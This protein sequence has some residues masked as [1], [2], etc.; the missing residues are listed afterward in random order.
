MSDLE[1]ELVR[2]LASGPFHRA[3]SLAVRR[4][5]LT[6]DRLCHRLA[7]RDIRLSTAA[8]SYWA[9]GR[10]RP[11]RGDSLKGVVAL[12]EVLGLPPGA[13]TALLP[14]PRPRG[15]Y[16]T[17]LEPSLRPWRAGVLERMAED[18]A[19]PAHSGLRR[20]SVDEHVTIDAE[21]CERTRRVREVMR[22][23]RD[24]LSRFYLFWQVD[25]P[26]A[27][28]PGFTDLWGCRPGRHRWDPASGYLITEMLLDSRLDVGDTAIVRYT[29][30]LPGHTPVTR[31]TRTVSRTV[32]A[33]ALEVTFAPGTVPVRCASFHQAAADEADEDLRDL[34]VDPS[35]SVHLALIEARPG[36][37]GIQ[38]YW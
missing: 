1:L 32:H 7:E 5:G 31:C 34:R 6:L 12:E 37:Y 22:A 38:L 26:T 24:D 11:E 18:L 2:A 35:G 33:F 3:L 29:L 8:L 21:R 15:R 16:S 20:L 14:P 25:D 9:S 23:E 36:V 28:R 4:R 27:G 19:M 10:R 13:L 17:G 30:D